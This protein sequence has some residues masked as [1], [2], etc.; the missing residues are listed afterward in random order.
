M[1]EV[2]TVY[3]ILLAVYTYIDSLYNGKIENALA[4]KPSYHSEDNK[5]N[6]NIIKNSL[7]SQLLPL[8]IL[9]IVIFAILV[10]YSIQIMQ[11]MKSEGLLHFDIF[12]SSMLLIVVVFLY[13][14]TRNIYKLV[15]MIKKLKNVVGDK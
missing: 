5:K 13:W 15:L 10:T 14:V 1:S 4:I 11:E 12:T 3:G 2:I 7:L 6:I 8:L 9:S